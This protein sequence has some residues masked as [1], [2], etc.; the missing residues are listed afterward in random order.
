MTV[1][2]LMERNGNQVV[3]APE[4]YEMLMLKSFRPN[5]DDEYHEIPLV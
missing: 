2:A 5:D 1:E 4:I 3:A